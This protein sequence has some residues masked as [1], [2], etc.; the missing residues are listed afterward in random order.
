MGK[1]ILII[2]DDQDIV[3]LLEYRLISQGYEVLT[4]F[5]G[6]KGLELAKNAMPDLIT[7]DIN[8]PEVNGFTVCSMLKADEVYH[9]IPIIVITARDGYADN[10]FDETVK[11]EAYVTKP[12]DMNELIE[13]IEALIH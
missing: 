13:K 12:F 6:A 2:E 4:A 9:S 10:V 3:S 7:L 8:L 5:D 11:P 1:K